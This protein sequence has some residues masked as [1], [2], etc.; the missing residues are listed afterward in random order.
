MDVH[1]DARDLLAAAYEQARGSPDPSNQCGAVVT[2]ANNEILGVGRNTFPP[3]FLVDVH[4]VSREEKLKN[5]EHAERAALYDMLRNG[6]TAPHR[7]FCPWA[8][9]H[10]CARA[11][12]SSGIRELWYHIERMDQT[13]ERWKADVDEALNKLKKGGVR[14]VSVSG[15]IAAAPVLVNGHLWSPQTCQFV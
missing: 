3:G 14:V 6:N 10:E 1:T 9:C 8:A 2:A 4:S 13:P 11:I 5:I 12:V 7:M 15:S